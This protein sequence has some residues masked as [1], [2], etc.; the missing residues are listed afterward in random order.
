MTGRI[1]QP[2]LDDLLTRIDIVAL[3]NARVQLR[4]TG[5]KLFRLLPLSQ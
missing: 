1:P 3:V 2:F 4:K 5:A